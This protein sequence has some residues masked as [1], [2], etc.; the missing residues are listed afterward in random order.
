MRVMRLFTISSPWIYDGT[1]TKGID[2]SNPGTMHS[3]NNNAYIINTGT[4]WNAVKQTIGVTPNKNYRMTVWLQ[5]TSNITAGFFGVANSSGG[6][7]KDQQFGSLPGYTM[8]TLD[9]NSGSNSTVTPYAD[10]GPGSGAYLRIDD[11]SVAPMN[12]N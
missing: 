3:G 7:L 2:R 1:D 5:G 12:W 10:W 11:M 8:M 9:F 4:A 6:V